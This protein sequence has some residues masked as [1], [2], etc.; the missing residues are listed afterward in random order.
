MLTYLFKELKKRPG[1]TTQFILDN[2]LI[3]AIYPLDNTRFPYEHCETNFRRYF[4]SEESEASYAFI[5]S[6]SLMLSLFFLSAVMDKSPTEKAEILAHLWEINQFCGVNLRPIV[7]VLGSLPNNPQQLSVWSST[8]KNQHPVLNP[9]DE[10]P[11]N[12][13]CMLLIL[14]NP[15]PTAAQKAIESPVAAAEPSG[16]ARKRGTFFERQKAGPLLD[17][18]QRASPVT[19]SSDTSSKQKPSAGTPFTPFG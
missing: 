16:L 17:E 3:K 19:E 7:S 10:N 15:A 14:W 4:S 11:A 9:F 2:Q 1:Q 5:K 12:L 6:P 13:S 8:F 18:Q